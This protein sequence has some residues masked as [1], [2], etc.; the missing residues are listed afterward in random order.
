MDQEQ[1]KA[2]VYAHRTAIYGFNRKNDGPAMSVVYYVMDGDDML[3][4]TMEGRGKAKTL[5][6]TP[7]VSLCVLDEHWPLT[8]LQIYA[9]ATID[10]T[11]DT[12]LEKVTDLLMRILGLMAGKSMPESVREQTRQM[13]LVERR[14]QLRV[15]P[16]D[17]FE[18]PP[19]HVYSSEDV[20][21]LTHDL[22][23]HLLW[24]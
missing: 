9:N 4:S 7:K 15:P 11:V 16:Y 8:Y 5:L 23:R 18:S 19:R 17:T 1:R 22:G 13:A 3:I 6:R 21:D 10:A 20:A 24:K 14:V 2:F 12:D